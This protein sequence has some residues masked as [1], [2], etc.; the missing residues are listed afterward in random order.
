VKN[1]LVDS[2]KIIVVD[3]EQDIRESVKDVL[4]DNNF[5]VETA[6]NGKDFIQ[7]I[8]K[9]NFDL[10]ILDVLMP[11]LTTREI[12]TELE[13]RKIKT[14]I[15]FLTVVRLADQAKETITPQMVDYIEKPFDNDDL[16]RRIKKALKD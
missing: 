4:K 16:I 6:E 12:I 14:K 15:I 10:I 8:S 2:K 7:K 3:D 13:K 1:T 9:K 11:G 5:E